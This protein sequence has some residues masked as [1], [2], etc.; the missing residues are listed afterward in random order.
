MTAEPHTRAVVIVGAGQAG[1]EAAA[2]LR[3]D[4]H[5]GPIV[6]VGDE[7]HL[8]YTRP[9]LSKAFLL[10]KVGADE[11]YLR[12]APFYETQAIRTIIDRH[13]ESIDREAKSVLLDD[14]EQIAYSSLV[15]ATGGSARHLVDPVAEAAPNVHY[16]RGIADVDA[17]RPGFRP[18]ARLVV[19][20]GGYV[21]LEVAAV[22]RQLGLE[23]TVL[24]AA[25]RLLAR[26][27]G[28]EVSAFF[29]RVHEEEG[30]DVRVDALV[31]G[32]ATADD[33]NVTSVTLQDGSDVPAD[34]VLVGIGLVP[35][36]RI[37]REAGLAVDGGIL[38]DE[39]GRTS[40]PDVFAIGDCS[41]HPC[42]EHGG[43]RRL[44]S[45]PNASEQARVVAAAITG[46]PRSYTS[47]PWFWSDQYDLKLQSV[48][49][50]TG[51][52]TVVVR[53]STQTDR[54]FVVFYLKDGLVRAADV[55]GSPRD[56][57][58]AKKIVAGRVR[59]APDRL[60]DE[61][62]PLKELLAEAQVVAG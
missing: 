4:G 49:L 21:G 18:G 3:M 28:P 32:F 15:L 2:A 54:K 36:D 23:V 43:L 1:G 52:D 16:L 5:D 11:L 60:A 45:V 14:G 44:E 19:V 13:V 25:P 24:E 22:A 39:V 59:L 46:D 9:P 35:N 50:A 33:G 62:V 31:T 10:G 6:L 34:L 30:V 61:D 41:V 42:F 47:V 55:V 26:V 38:V 56:F 7:G 12:P 27:A 20:G 37:A 53:G 8:P 58:M 17:L 29:R 48:G 51:H 40:D 57:G